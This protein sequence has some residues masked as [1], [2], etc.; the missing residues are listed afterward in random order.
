MTNGLCCVGS[1]ALDDVQTMC[2]FWYA[3]ALSVCNA[4]AFYSTYFKTKQKIME[5]T[6]AQISEWIE[7]DCSRKS[8][9]TDPLSQSVMGFII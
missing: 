3:L 1:S 2:F 4:R 9:C 7:T 6:A 8:T 5:F